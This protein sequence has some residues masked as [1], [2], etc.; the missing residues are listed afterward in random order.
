MLVLHQATF[1][2]I[3]LLHPDFQR[4]NKIMSNLLELWCIP[5]VSIIWCKGVRIAV[6][7]QRV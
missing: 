4:Q 3:L 7:S 6:L 5:A 2:V 1:Q